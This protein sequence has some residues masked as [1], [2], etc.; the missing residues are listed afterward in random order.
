MCTP[1]VWFKCLLLAVL[2]LAGSPSTQAAFRKETVALETSVPAFAGTEAEAFSTTISA[3]NNNRL[4]LKQRRRINRKAIWLTLQQRLWR[5]PG[6]H[7]KSQLTAFFLC[8]FLGAV[9]IHRFYLGYTLI[10]LLQLLA[11]LLMPLFISIALLGTVTT[12]TVF[13]VGFFPI[14]VILAY[15]I[16]ILTDFVRIITGDLKPKYS[17]YD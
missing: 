14:F 13:T 8:L 2:L 12:A 10:G 9:G 17:N 4:P 15:L 6:S 16:W 5:T 11:F 3:F 7:S 1:G